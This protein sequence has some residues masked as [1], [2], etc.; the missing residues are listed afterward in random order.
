MKCVINNQVVLQQAPEG[1]LESYIGPFVEFISAQGYALS[2]IHRHAYLAAD[3]SR[4]LK[5]FDFLRKEL[6]L[7]SLTARY[8][9][10]PTVIY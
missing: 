7:R 9:F 6:Q 8:R 10:H 1:P 2:S 5:K 4:W 3:F